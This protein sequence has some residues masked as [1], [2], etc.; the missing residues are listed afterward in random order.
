MTDR[1]GV[2]QGFSLAML[3]LPEGLICWSVLVLV[4]LFACRPTGPVDIDTRTDACSRCRMPIDGLAH[5][6]EMIT[7]EGRVRKY[8][9]LGGLVEDYRE[10]LAAGKKAAG[11]WVIDYRAKH[12]LP[13]D[14]AH[15]ALADLPTDH[16]GYGVAAMASRD[17]ALTLVAGDAA[18][19]VT[20][21]GLLAGAHRSGQHEDD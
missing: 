9:S 2:G 10:A 3:G 19:V 16:M 20:W 14:S 21:E 1:R 18:K 11:V 6:G 12:W 4:V 8:D 15:Y 13:A 7:A 5:A 17:A